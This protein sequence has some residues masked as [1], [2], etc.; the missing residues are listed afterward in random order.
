MSA[1]KLSNKALLQ[2]VVK[3]SLSVAQVLEDFSL[4]RH[5]R[6]YDTFY[7]YCELYNIDFSHFTGSNPEPARIKNTIV[8]SEILVENSTYQWTSNLRRRLIREGLLEN[9]CYAFNCPNPEP[10][11]A[12]KPLVMHLDH[13]NGVRSDNR[14]ENLRI[15]CPNCH[16]QTETYSGKSSPKYCK[17]GKEIGRSSTSCVGCSNKSRGNKEPKYEWPPDDELVNLVKNSSWEATA[18]HVGCGSGN[19]VKKR[20]LSRGYDPK[21]IKSR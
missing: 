5:G 12:E 11:W 16:S 4:R 19:T 10:Y 1:S 20:L 6:N 15:L 7:K 2:A 3:S 17:C 14:L 9:R 21:S 13:I 18:R 8:L